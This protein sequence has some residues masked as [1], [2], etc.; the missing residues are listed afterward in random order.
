[1][2]EYAMD[3]S[4]KLGKSMAGYYEN[5]KDYIAPRE[6]TVTITLH[7]YRELVDACAKHEK[8]VSDMREDYENK[9]KNLQDDLTYHKT[10]IERL[11]EELSPQSDQDDD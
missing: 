1:M 2:A 11:K 8:T 6:I 4:I 9:I 3:E 7:E 5:S 10:Q